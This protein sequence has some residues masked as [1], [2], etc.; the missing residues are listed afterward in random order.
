[1]FKDAVDQFKEYAKLMYPAE[2][3]GYVVDDEFVPCRNISSS[4]QHHFEISPTEYPVDGLQAVLHSHTNGNKS[5]SKEDMEGQVRSAKPWGISTVSDSGIVSDPIWWG[6]GIEIP[7]IKNR[8]YRWG[9]SGSDGAGDCY[10]LIKDWYKLEKDI[11]LPEFPRQWDDYQHPEWNMYLDNFKSA[12]FE[13]V[14][15]DEAE[16]GDVILMKIPVMMEWPNHAGIY[17][18]PTEG[19][20][21][22]LINRPSNQESVTRWVKNITHFLRRKK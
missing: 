6:N 20:I 8:P 12:G 13:E 21:H 5:P 4:P 16:R 10:A 2:A 9:P 14:Y 18:G 11:D 19:M 22:H 7:P 3:C 15:Q 17:L 1:M